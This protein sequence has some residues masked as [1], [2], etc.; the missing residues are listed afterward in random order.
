MVRGV[1]GTQ[2]Y[3]EQ[4]AELLSRYDNILFEDVHASVM[5]LIPKTSGMALDLGAGTGRDAAHL[6]GLGHKVVA[7]EPTDEFRNSASRRYPHIEW[8]DDALPELGK[9]A[10]RIGQFDFIMA[11]AMWMHLD[12]AE[13]KISMHNVAELLKPEGLLIMSI[14]CGPTPAGRLMYD[15]SASET[16]LLAANDGLEVI[17]EKVTP[18]LGEANKKAGVKWLRLVFRNSSR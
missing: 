10:D 12:E 2:G 3:S 17:F 4:S 6:T 13:R 16:K 8:I 5:H 11:T 9:L 14:R 1:K 15:V 18:S 7:V